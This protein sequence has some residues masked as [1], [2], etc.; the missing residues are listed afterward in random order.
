[1]RRIVAAAAIAAAIATLGSPAA[2]AAD[3]GTGFYV[4]AGIGA[5]HFDQDFG[6]AVRNAY[7][8]TVFTVTSASMTDDNGTT[9]L[10]YAG[11]QFHPN[12]AVE[13]AY[14]DLGKAKATY[15]LERQGTITRDAE[16]KASAATV[17]LVGSVPVGA[18]FS[19]FAK[20]GVAW[21]KLKYHENIDDRGVP[22]SFT[23]PDLNQTRG[24]AGIGAT[25]AATPNLSIRGE[26]DRYFDVGNTFALTSEGNGRFS[27]IDALWIGVQYRFQ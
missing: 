6:A 1:M 23:A 13:A 22:D 27:S 10:V 19:L 24:T 16:Y 26:W 5:T 4:G 12:F 8:G 14:T 15:T 3:A 2:G 18:G 11:W 21:T 17:S 20:G 25:Y 9:G 7:D